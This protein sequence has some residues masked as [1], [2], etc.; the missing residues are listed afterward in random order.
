MTLSIK[1]KELNLVTNKALITGANKGI[2]FEI[3]RQLGQKGW[4]ILLGARSEKRGLE[5]V[6]KLR[7]EGIVVEWIQI[8]LNKFETIYNAADYVNNHH[9]DLNALVNN[10]GIPGNMP[11][12][13]LDVPIEELRELTEV[14]FFGNFEMIKTFTPVLEKNTGRILNVTIPSKPSVFIDAFSYTA[15][16]A[17][18]NAMIKLFARDFKKKKIPVEIF[19]LTPGGITTDLNNNQTGPFMRT[20][21]EGAAS[22][23]N[24]ITD[25]R[26]HQ[27]KILI[28]ITPFNLFRKNK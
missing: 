8:D 14:N 11:A 23:V 9:S 7:S 25:H 15:T 28:R 10:A 2:G 3:A 1:E 5:A 4:S 13:P 24:V 18:L 21:K 20:A 22:I 19:G 6:E 16:K 12:A 17:G 26:N 27:G